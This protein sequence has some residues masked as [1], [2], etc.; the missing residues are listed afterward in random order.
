MANKS[1][2]Y[3]PQAAARPGDKPDFSYLHLSPAGSVDKPSIDARTSEIENLSY[4]LVRV[5]DDDH[6]AKGPW[7]PNLDLD[8]L[9][10]ALR[11]RRRALQTQSMRS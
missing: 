4:E 2:L 6:E 5:L 1:R 8:K 7:H 9:Q 11:C 3:I 10:V